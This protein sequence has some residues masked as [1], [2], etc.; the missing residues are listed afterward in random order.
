L[1]LYSKKE[2]I[3]Y[4]SPLGDADEGS[5]VF[6]STIGCLVVNGM[7]GFPA[8]INFETAEVVVEKF[9]FCIGSIC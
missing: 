7:D 3:G 4:L 9:T 8:L 2:G 6:L 5:D 1:I